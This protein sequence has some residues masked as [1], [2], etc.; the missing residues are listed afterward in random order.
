MSRVENHAQ[1]LARQ[2]VLATQK[3]D[4]YIGETVRCLLP[5]F[6]YISFVP[7]TRSKLALVRRRAGGNR[8]GATRSN[9][10]QLR[11]D[12]LRPGRTTAPWLYLGW[13]A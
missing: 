11:A 5:S 7:F 6:L 12:F 4:N 1:L 2:P 13:F 8:G 3:G 10:E 9:S